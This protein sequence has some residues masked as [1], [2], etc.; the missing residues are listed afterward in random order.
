MIS[1]IP[2]KRSALVEKVLQKM[3]A[4]LAEVSG[5]DR[6]SPELVGLVK[7]SAE[8]VERVVWEV[9]PELAE[10]IIKENLKELTAKKSN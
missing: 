7:L 1:Q 4:R 8:V 6:N 3:G 9:V 5:L 2:A 10:Q